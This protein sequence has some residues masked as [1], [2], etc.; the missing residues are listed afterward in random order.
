MDGKNHRE[1]KKKKIRTD[2]QEKQGRERIRDWATNRQTDR[3]RG[4]RK[5][6][7]RR[8]EIGRGEV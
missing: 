3:E 4:K 6:G 2:G 5:K 7:E 1:G 8:M